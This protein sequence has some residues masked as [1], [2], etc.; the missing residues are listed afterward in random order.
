[1]RIREANRSEG[2]K[3]TPES[4]CRI[5]R[6]VKSRKQCETAPPRQ[7]TDP[8]I[9]PMPGEL[10]AVRTMLSE[11]E[12]MLAGLFGPAY[13]RAPLA[14]A[15]RGKA[16]E[17]VEAH[18][19]DVVENWARAMEQSFEETKTLNRQGLANSLVRFLAHLRNPDDLTT[20]VYLRRH[21][22]EGMLARAKPSQF[23]IF[24]I[25]LKQV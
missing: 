20:F 17:L 21:C 24:H 13:D 7:A 15:A 19:D 22:Q 9:E 18:F 3:I 23:N 25:A 2:G 11:I 1:M 5:S 6:A 14:M 16:A 12:K 8:P 4:F 10:E